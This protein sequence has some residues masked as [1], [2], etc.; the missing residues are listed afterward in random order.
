MFRRLMSTL[1]KADLN[2]GIDW[3]EIK[4]NEVVARESVPSP[5]LFS[6][7]QTLEQVLCESGDVLTIYAR[8]SRAGTIRRVRFSRPLDGRDMSI[9]EWTPGEKPVYRLYLAPLN[10]ESVV[11]DMCYP[12][13]FR[14]WRNEP[15]FDS[16]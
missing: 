2:P 14:L 12:T 5:M 16:L 8:W 7:E 1:L 11:C 13:W 10:G 4:E 15:T 9:I 3:S 6:R